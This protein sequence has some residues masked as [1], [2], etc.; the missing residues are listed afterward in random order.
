MLLS[1]IRP[2][3]GITKDD[4]K[5]KLAVSK[6]YDFTKGSTDVFNQRM[7]KFSTKA[8]SNKW[9]R[10]AF[11]Y[12]LDKARV[13]ASTVLQLTLEDADAEIDAFELGWALTE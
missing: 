6:L 2:I 12:L 3:L 7:S 1:T 9:T 13:N 5:K 4:G 10:V 8:K 11:S